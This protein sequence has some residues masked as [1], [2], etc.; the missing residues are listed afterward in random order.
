LSAVRT[1]RAAF[2]AAFVCASAPR[3]LPQPHQ[4]ERLVFLGGQAAS[5]TAA[6]G[7]PDERSRRC[8]SSRLYTSSTR[9]WRC[10]SQDGNMRRGPEH[11]G[12]Q[13]L[14]LVYVAQKLKHALRAEQ[15]LTDAGLDYLVESDEYAVG[16]LF[17]RVRVGAFFYVLPGTDRAARDVLRRG[18]FVPS[19]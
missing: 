17:R 4:V 9:S 8:P 3:F 15:L 1:D 19:P 13:E 5:G 14:S 10:L 11:F 16:L 18:G 2:P 6:H 12:E 7:L